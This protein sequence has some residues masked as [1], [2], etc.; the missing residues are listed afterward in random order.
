[1]AYGI[2]LRLHHG[3]LR[4]SSIL[5]TD[6]R[7]ATD[8]PIYGQQRAG[9]VY[10][11]VGGTI[12]LQFTSDVA[13]SYS[14]GVIRAFLD[15]GEVTDEF[16]FD[17]VFIAGIGGA[18]PPENVV[19]VHK[20]GDDTDPAGAG[21]YLTIQAAVDS[22]T[23]EAPTKR[24]V[25]KVAPGVYTENVVLP[26]YIGLVGDSNFGPTKQVSIVSASGHT[27]TI[28]DKN[29]LVYGIEAES[30]SATVTD[31]A[32]HIVDASTPNLL[33]DAQ[34][35]TIAVQYTSNNGRAI[36]GDN[37]G[38][39]PG[40]NIRNVIVAY[41]GLTTRGAGGLCG[42]LDGAGLS[43]FIGGCDVLDPG[44]NGFILQ[45]SSSIM[46]GCSTSING[47]SA[48][49]GGSGSWAVQ[50]DSSA[51]IAVDMMLN[52]DNGIRLV[53]G[54]VMFAPK[55]AALG[56]VPDVPLFSDNTSFVLL[57]DVQL[58]GFMGASWANWNIQGFILPLWRGLRSYGTTGAGGP[59]QRPT[60][61]GS[62]VPIGFQY[63]AMDL[64]AGGVG[65]LLTWSG[66]P[67][68][69]FGQWTDGLGNIIP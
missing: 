64:G 46:V 1:M 27:L 53:N 4:N 55:L 65:M 6:L 13:L 57:G 33:T 58:D 14:K 16:V 41:A 51:V 67:P 34:T 19:R 23:D 24:Y 48:P 69:G 12:E 31:S 59:D 10:V 18:N 29:S 22:I 47:Y 11:P 54:S 42:F 5:I 2:V 49:G 66:S 36:F 7:E 3:G 56:G 62:N 8:G 28:P 61:S 60:A 30:T 45:N 32:I 15:N 50:A 68:M 37:F 43:W 63:Y 38:L 21:G 44:A 17:P 20:G 9:A 39:D 25:V 52:G 26:E 35:F 40:G